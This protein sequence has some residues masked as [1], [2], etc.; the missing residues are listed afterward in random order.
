MAKI[1]KSTFPREPEN[2]LAG[3]FKKLTREEVTEVLEPVLPL[4]KTAPSYHQMIALAVGLL[5][6]HWLFALDM[7][8]GKSKIAI[9]IFSIRKSLGEVHRAI[10]TAPPIVI[11]HW[12]NEVHKHSDLT[13]V[14]IEGTASE[15]FNAL[16]NVDADFIIVSHPWI[17]RVFSDA[18]TGKVPYDLVKNAMERFDVLIIDEAHQLKNSESVGLQG[19]TNFL[20]NTQYRYLLTGTPIG[21]NYLG[22]WAL[23]YLLDKGETFTENYQKFLHK[24]FSTILLEKFNPKTQ[25]TFKFP[26]YRLRKDRKEAFHDRFWN[27]AIRWEEDELNDLPEKNYLSLP[28]GMTPMQHKEYATCQKNDALSDM[29]KFFELMRI[30]GGATKTLSEAKQL[31]TKLQA[32]K[33]LIE[34]VVIDNDNPLII[35]CH[36][37][38]EG[39]ALGEFIRKS[40]KK[41]RFGEVRGE[42]PK[43]K[44][45]KILEDWHSGKIKI[46]IANE[47]SL[48]VGVDLYEANVDVFYS[49]GSS[50]I[51]R[52]QAE[53]RIHRKGQ[54]KPCL[55]IDLVCTGTVDSLILDNL[56]SAQKSFATLTK[57]STWKKPLKSN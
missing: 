2:S 48:G 18:S 1:Q 52:R 8:L 15:K 21:N 7:G 36:L 13:A 38:E 45:D 31:P 11:R 51:N 43:A 16:L 53:K 27:K 23:Y 9:D 24:W 44:K 4:L 32:V 3:Q 57:D 22:I 20:L 28:L 54:T 30:T 40:F 39:K 17:S 29:E 34:E 6:E 35:W 56:T 42:I 33:H 25:R 41:I 14:A 5:Q 46:L 19:Y 37:V 12:V 49:N 47:A 55:H 10:I 26:I 50:L